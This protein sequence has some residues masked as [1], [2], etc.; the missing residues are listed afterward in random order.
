MFSAIKPSLAWVLSLAWDG[1]SSIIGLRWLEF[2]HWLE[3]AWVL[4]LAWDGL[5]SIT[6]GSCHK[7]HFCRDKSFVMTKLCLSGQRFCRNKH[8]FVTTKDVFC[9][10]KSKLVQQIFVATNIFLS[11]QKTCFVKTNMFFSRQKWCLWQLLPMIE[12]IWRNCESAAFSEIE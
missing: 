4:S 10:D 8:A 11:W 6:G 7:Y 12:L 9:C 2:Y 1:L 5:S 3:M